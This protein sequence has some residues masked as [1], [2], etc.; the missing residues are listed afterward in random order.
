MGS[1][2]A[3][4][5]IAALL[6]FPAVSCAAMQEEIDHLLNYIKTSDCVFIRNNSPHTP[7]KAVKHIQ[8]KYNYLKKRIK[9]TEDF[10][11]GAATQSS[12]SGKPYMI[13][14]D[15]KEMA[16]ADWLRAELQRYRT[17]SVSGH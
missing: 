8:K 15:G 12:I 7:E 10:I 4:L 14:C 16:T 2:Y 13:I 6:F 17:K 5:F 3:A 9:A 1:Q 11:Q